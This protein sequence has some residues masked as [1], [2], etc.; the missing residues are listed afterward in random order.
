MQS[1]AGAMLA[2]PLA[3]APTHPPRIRPTHKHID[4]QVVVLSNATLEESK[5]IDEIC[6]A[7]SPAIAFVRAE[8]RGVFASVFCDFGPAF[9]VFDTDGALMVS[10]EGGWPRAGSLQQVQTHAAVCR[11]STNPPATHRVFGHPQARRPTAASWRPSPAAA[12]RW[13][14]ASMTSAWS[15]RWGT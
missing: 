14:P 6:R 12:P 11:S 15:S 13:S 7:A 10:Y 3:H 8:T 9:T 4:T 5:R 2:P 1:D